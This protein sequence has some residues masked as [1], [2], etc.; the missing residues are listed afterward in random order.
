MMPT[1]DL[2]LCR[3][4][5]GACVGYRCGAKGHVSSERRMGVGDGEAGAMKQIV[6]YKLQMTV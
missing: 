3:V 5:I 2:V 1:S 4:R 6:Q